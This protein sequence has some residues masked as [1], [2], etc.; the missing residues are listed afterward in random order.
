MG[1]NAI[2]L[3][4]PKE[5]A[6][7]IELS[8]KKGDR[9]KWLYHDDEQHVLKTPNYKYFWLMQKEILAEL[10]TLRQAI[11]RLAGTQDLP[12][13]KQLSAASLGQGHRRVQKTRQS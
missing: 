12:P 1:V 11:V 5:S 9:A 4:I 3:T 8:Q 13:A 7:A 2:S 6:A 10:Q